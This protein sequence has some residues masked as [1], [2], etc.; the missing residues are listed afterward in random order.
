MA[1]FRYES[2]HR[3]AMDMTKDMSA[4][5]A[6][7]GMDASRAITAPMPYEDKL[8]NDK[9]GVSEQELSWFRSVMGSLRWYAQARYDIAYEVSTIA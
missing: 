7:I 3:R 4:F 8:T 5:L 2:T 9:N 1:G 6:D